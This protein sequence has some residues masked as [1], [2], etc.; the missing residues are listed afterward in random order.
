MA[1]YC[2]VTPL[3]ML[4]Q[5]LALALNL[6]F[7]RSFPM[8]YHRRICRIMGLRVEARGE[9]STVRP[10]LFVSNHVSYLD[11]E[12]LGSLIKGSFVA[13]AEVRQW[14]I[15]GW[16]ARLQRSVFVERRAG[17]AAES[18]DEMGDRLNA[19]DS[20]ILFP[21]GTTS[22]GNRILPFKSALFSVAD[23]QVDGRPLVVQAVSVA[24]AKLDGMPM[25]RY[26]RP[27]VAW[28]GAM[29]LGGHFARMF[30]LGTV[31]VIVEFHP[32]VTI[33]LFANR[34]AL[35]AYCQAQVSR[36]VVTALTGRPQPEL[37]PPAKP[38]PAALPMPRLGQA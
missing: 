8:W 17:R 13:K 21:E 23:R 7:Q 14:P 12:V 38:L 35:A 27:Y 30:G 16:L 33:D 3:C 29:E 26:L 25:G 11:I 1:A 18:R 32:P 34:K 37:P 2:I 24:Y 10:T 31:T 9:Q 22:D 6:P 5:A 19:G 36:G 20:L 28:Y 15:F 4:V